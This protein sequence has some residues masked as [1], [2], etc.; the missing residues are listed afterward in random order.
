MCSKNKVPWT[1]DQKINLSSLLLALMSFAF[2]TVQ[3][4]RADR[5][6]NR[7][8]AEAAQVVLLQ[9]KKEEWIDYLTKELAV[10]NRQ[11]E[12]I[13]QRL[14][15]DSIRLSFNSPLEKEKAEAAMARDLQ[16]LTILQE[17]KAT[18]ERQISNLQ[19]YN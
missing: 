15:A 12:D 5:E 1:R 13:E 18:I 16:A 3:Y 6:K 2:G 19:S 17:K 8:D 7:A 10:N 9:K 11:L 14:Q 4:I